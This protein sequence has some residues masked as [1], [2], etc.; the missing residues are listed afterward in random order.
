MKSRVTLDSIAVAC[1]VKPATVSRVLNNVSKGFSVSDEKR[2]LIMS[3]A[4]KMGYVPNLAAKNLRLN[5]TNRI[6]IYGLSI[7]WGIRE[8]TYSYMLHSC[9]QT[10]NNAGFEADVVYPASSSQVL[11]P[12]AFDGAVIIN[13][14][15]DS[16]QEYMHSLRTP[17]VLMNDRPEKVACS[18]VAVDDISGMKKAIAHLR[19]NGHNRI[20]YRCGENSRNKKFRHRSINDRY[21]TYISEMQKAKLAM[22]SDYEQAIP[23]EDFIDELMRRKISAVIT[24]DATNALDMLKN[25]AQSKIKIPDDLSIITFNEPAYP[26]FPELT[27]IKL[28]LTEM[29]VAAAE[30]LIARLNGEKELRQFVFDEMLAEGHSVA[31]LKE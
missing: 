28:P 20:A 19:E 14:G 3:T 1:N 30:S 29:G 6:M 4:N 26:T 27:I 16:I 15:N 22:F 24:Y 7:G 17:F 31:K 8:T 21:N 25:C 9:I 10:L 13:N 11:S 23:A 18:Y 5:R 12:M 2:E